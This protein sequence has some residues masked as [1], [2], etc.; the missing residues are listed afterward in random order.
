MSKLAEPM[1]DGRYIV[2]PSKI[3]W[4]DVLRF[5]EALDNGPFPEE[6]RDGFGARIIKTLLG[7]P[8]PKDVYVVRHTEAMGVMLDSAHGKGD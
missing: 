2:D 6:P 5:E 3:E 4:E 7:I 8:D 1:G